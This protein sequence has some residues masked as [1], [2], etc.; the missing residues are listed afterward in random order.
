MQRK[1]IFA[2]IAMGFGI[3]MELV[4]ALHLLIG[5][6]R[7]NPSSAQSAIPT[8]VS[9]IA[10]NYANGNTEVN[11]PRSDFDQSPAGDQ[12]NAG[13]NPS[14]Q[15]PQDQNSPGV[16]PASPSNGYGYPMVD[17]DHPP[18]SEPDDSAGQPD[19]NEQGPGNGSGDTYP[20]PST[21]NTQVPIPPQ[22]SSTPPPAS[23]T[24]QPTI[25]QTNTYPAA[26]ATP[27]T[28]TP[29]A[30]PTGT[31]ALPSGA[32]ELVAVR[33]AK[34]PKIDGGTD[35]AWGEA[36]LLVID[37]SGGAN[38]SAA[39]VSIRSMY[40]G[41]NI[42]FLF[43][44]ADSSQSFLLNPWEREKD[45]VWKKLVGA[46]NHGGDENQYYMD[47]LALLWP[48]A[49]SLPDFTAHGCAAACH[50]GE[51]PQ[52][53]AT[54]LMY[55]GGSGQSADLWQWKS[56]ANTGQVDDDF[57][58]HTHY[59]KDTPWAGFHSDPGSGGYS[60]NQTK[61]HGSPAYMP[62]GGGDKNGAPGFILDAEK[63][64]LDEGLFN[65]GD[66]LPGILVAPFQG[67]RG[68]IRAVWSHKNGTWTL[69]L[70]RKLVTGSPYDV[71]FDDL[72]KT[73]TFALATFD[74]T[75]VRHAVQNG[76]AILRFNK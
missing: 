19:P 6:A 3:S 12:A 33:A 15:A 20:A 26:S 27:F 11:A 5:P 44:W 2:L 49:S 67:D 61:D 64:K 1:I 34:P 65:P 56:V 35:P 57:L 38:H 40:D 10:I 30:E 47:K 51:Q 25:A 17:S 7:N 73:Y 55:T 60:T 28:K 39:Q 42:Y 45:S 52:V 68:D 53:K 32:G 37:T 50:S 70:S 23:A 46:D 24:L 18:G 76:A 8:L 74:N 43:T 9:T 31:P 36:P 58:D 54:G 29:P 62:P 71:Q 14:E 13:E 69:E 48:I 66:R 41:E 75:Q 63:V 16:D 4:L 72:G 59:S 21:S 22:P